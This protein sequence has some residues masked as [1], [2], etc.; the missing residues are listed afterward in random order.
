MRVMPR[1]VVVMSEPSVQSAPKPVNPRQIEWIMNSARVFLSVVLVPG[2]VMSCATVPQAGTEQHRPS[3]LHGEARAVETAK[4]PLPS[5]PR[6]YYHFILGYQAEL[7]RDTE[8]AL[9]EYQLALRGDSSSV[10]LKGRIASLFFSIGDVNN[11]TRMADRISETD[12]RDVPTFILLAGIYAGANQTERALGLY[13]RAI[14]LKTGGSDAYFSKG[15]LLINLKR[16]A[17]AERVFEQGIALG[18]D[19]PIGYYYLGRIAVETKQLDRAIVEFERSVTVHPTFEPGYIALASVYEAREDREKAAAVYRRYLDTVNSHSK[20]I[21][22]QLIRLYISG[23]S[24]DAALGEL[25]RALAQDPSDL[26]AQL[27]AGLI[28]GELKQYRKAIEQLKGILALRPA[29]LKVRDYLG[30]MYEELKEYEEAIR[31]YEENIKFQPS[32]VDGHMHMGF[33]LYRLKRYPDAIRHLADAIKLNPKH[34]DAHL[35]LG[36]TYLQ[37][38]EYGAASQA[39]EEGIR[40]N[41]ENPDLHFNLGTAYDKLNRFEDVV[42]SME[43]ALRLDPKHADAL[44]YLGYSYAERGIRIEEAVSLIQRAVSLKPN[45]GYY[46]DSLGWAFFKMGLLE[47]ALVEIQRAASLVK[48]DPVIF[49]HLGEIFLKQNR[50]SEAREAWLHSLELDPSNLKLVERFRDQGFGD[51]TA[52]E[53]VRQA[54][55]RVSQ[56]AP[57]PQDAPLQATP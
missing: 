19:S 28:Y 11:A 38:E 7:E 24:Y 53:R 18:K 50:H 42:K 6:A 20:E 3:T 14:D 17:D 8:R 48:D 10:F 2:I 54:K 12:I 16:F 23:K 32:Y 22:Q 33:L 34:P 13:D 49:E 37:T 1:T 31:T 40:Q 9:R 56:H 4:P 57:L 44:N 43:A 29:E 27:R 51:A 55:R 39:F 5:D 26:D 46:V 36:L 41:P 25:E 45:N 52:D 30:L 21:R 15:T 47:E 35:L